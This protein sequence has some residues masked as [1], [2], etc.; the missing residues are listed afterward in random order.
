MY[1]KNMTIDPLLFADV[2]DVLGIPD[3]VIVEKDYYAV[4]LLKELDALHFDDYQL[5]FAGGTCLTKVHHNTYRMSED[6]DIK[7]VA[8]N[9]TLHLSHSKQRQR[10]KIIH[11]CILN[12]LESSSTFQLVET[13]KRDESRFQQF[14]IQYPRYHKLID[15]LRPHLKLEI[16][17][18]ILLEPAIEKPV[19][20]LY[21][22][23]VKSKPEIAGFPCVTMR[24]TA[25][26]KFVSLLRR[27]AAHDR[28]RTREDDETLI[29]HVYDLHLIGS[30][31]TDF[32]PIKT[33]VHQ[34][35]RIDA[36]Q[37]GNRHEQFREN[38][39]QEL[40]HGLN[41][42]IKNPIYKER[43][44]KFIGPLVYHPTPA[45]WDQA[46]KTIIQMADEWLN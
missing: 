16:T 7:L 27:T 26:E 4:S 14:L 38:P 34:V 44:K 31:L 41:L 40:K 10:R 17:E 18:S 12:L 25:S 8:S 1:E 20:S 46:I 2:A 29:R 37:F 9:E 5:V 23:T 13:K 36:E 24:S 21:A 35:M 43:Y 33:F 15:A 30:D 42:L 22:E 32:Q 3:P 45:T 11:Q 28:D 19:Y 39:I 6:I